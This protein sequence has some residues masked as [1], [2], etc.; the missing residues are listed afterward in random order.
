MTVKVKVLKEGQTE[1]LPKFFLEVGPTRVHRIAHVR[2]EMGR[3]RLLL[4]SFTTPP[5][6]PIGL[7]HTHVHA[8]GRVDSVCT[9]LLRLRAG[10]CCS[11]LFV[12][13]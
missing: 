7:T 9:V 5:I 2:V 8:V 1:L 12:A 13:T 4:T 10:E 3:I 11:C 6:N